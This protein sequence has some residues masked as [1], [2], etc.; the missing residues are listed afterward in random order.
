MKCGK[1]TTVNKNKHQVIMTCKNID[2]VKIKM[3]DNAIQVYKRYVLGQL[4]KQS[5]VDKYSHDNVYIQL[6]YCMVLNRYAVNNQSHCPEC[7]LRQ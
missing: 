5:H 2:K 7:C 6:Q 3:I 4:P 1:Y